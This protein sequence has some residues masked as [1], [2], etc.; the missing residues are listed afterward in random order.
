MS[1]PT[2]PITPIEKH[3]CEYEDSDELQWV[4]DGPTEPEEVRQKPEAHER[5]DH[6]HVA[7]GEIDEL[8]DPV[9]HRVAEGDERVDR[10][11]CHGVDGIAGSGSRRPRTFLTSSRRIESATVGSVTLPTVAVELVFRQP[12]G[13]SA[14]PNF[15]SF[16]VGSNWK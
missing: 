13:R 16:V 10:A 4:I 11:K 8:D 6:E 2:T 9:D 3:E 1:T 15:Q 12:L 7:M 5:A 14:E